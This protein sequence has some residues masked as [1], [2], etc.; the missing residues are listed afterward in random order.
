M[1]RRPGVANYVE[2]SGPPLHGLHRLSFS[3]LMDNGRQKIYAAAGYVGIYRTN[4][5]RTR[6]CLDDFSYCHTFHRSE[7][8]CTAGVVF[9]CAHTGLDGP[10]FRYS[11][12]LVAFRMKRSLQSHFHRVGSAL[13][14]QFSCNELGQQLGHAEPP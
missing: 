2:L 8:E 4:S 13:S 1:G 3:S 9:V 7:P 14:L 5:G 11:D 10:D 12:V 6:L